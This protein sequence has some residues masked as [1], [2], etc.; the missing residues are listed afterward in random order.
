[1]FKKISILTLLLLFFVSTTGLPLTIHFCNMAA[2]MEKMDMS[3]C[4]CHV[5]NT[6]RM[7][8]ACSLFKSETKEISV[9]S[10]NCCDTEVSFIKHVKDSFL[11]NKTE[12][13]KEVSI[14]KIHI[15]TLPSIS[16]R[17]TVSYFSF[18]DSSPPLLTSNHLYIY[19]SVFLI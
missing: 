19:N 4:S 18:T 3:S 7:H 5:K 2:N 17:Q 13:Q 10:Q 16:Q 11:S 12:I 14:Q 8:K 9:K 15:L 6:N 1:M